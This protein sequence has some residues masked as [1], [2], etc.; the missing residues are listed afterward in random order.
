MKQRAEPAEL[1][2]NKTTMC[3]SVSACASVIQT[4]MLMGS[5]SMLAAAA[6][7]PGPIAFAAYSYTRQ[8]PPTTTAPVLSRPTGKLDMSSLGSGMADSQK[9]EES[10]PHRQ[11]MA[12]IENASAKGSRSGSQP[13]GSPRNSPVPSP[14]PERQAATS[15]P[16]GGVLVEVVPR[17]LSDNPDLCLQDMGSIHDRYPGLPCGLILLNKVKQDWMI[18]KGV[19]VQWFSPSGE[20]QVGWFTIYS[21]TS[22]PG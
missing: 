3:C 6:A 14:E 4:L 18:R 17:P 15:G 8:L 10:N 5:L 12:R 1:K 11:K 13:S 7:G 19:T 22:F 16:G 2:Q 20:Q 21:A 9:I